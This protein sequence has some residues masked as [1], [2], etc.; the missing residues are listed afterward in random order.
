MGK[1]RW[2]HL[3]IADVYLVHPDGSGLKR[4]TEH[5]RF[6]DSPKWARDSKRVISHCMSGEETLT[7]RGPS[8]AQG[9]TRLVSIDIANGETADVPVGPGVRCRRPS[10]PPVRLPIYAK[11]P[12]P[13]IFYNVGRPGP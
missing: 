10:F 7:Y 2:E 13:G 1:G 4:L 3:Q 5:G 12:A 9:E 8:P 11:T 6:C